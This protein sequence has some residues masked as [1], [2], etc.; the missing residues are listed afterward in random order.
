MQ[1]GTNTRLACPSDR[2]PSQESI[3]ETHSTDQAEQDQF[4]LKI[5]GGSSAELFAVV[6]VVTV[7]ICAAAALLLSTPA[8]LE[9]APPA[10]VV[11]VNAAGV[12]QRPFHERHPINA[13]GEQVDPPTF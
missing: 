3:M 2:L 4:E 1:A 6:S 8:A 11:D 12:A 7:A 5:A 13:G 10:A 9:A